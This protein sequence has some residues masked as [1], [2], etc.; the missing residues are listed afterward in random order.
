MRAIKFRIWDTVNKKWID[1][2]REFCLSLNEGKWYENTWI[3]Q[4]FTGLLDE[5]GKEIYEGDI[6]LFQEKRGEVK[7]KNSSW[8]LV[9][10]LPNKM[11]SWW[12]AICDSPEVIGNIFENPELLQ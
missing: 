10:D 4:Q 7:F 9:N 1:G 12:L 5:N 8:F 6:V 11:E 2:P 3:F